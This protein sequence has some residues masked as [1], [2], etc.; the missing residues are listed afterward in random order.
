MRIQT[1][2]SRESELIDFVNCHSVLWYIPSQTFIGITDL[3]DSLDIESDEENKI[4]TVANPMLLL[5]LIASFKLMLLERFADL[6]SDSLFC[7]V[8][9][10]V[11]TVWMSFTNIISAPRV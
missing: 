8:Q 9:I 1:N 5:V 11:R 3:I 6:P 10:L 2:H 4:R 7:E